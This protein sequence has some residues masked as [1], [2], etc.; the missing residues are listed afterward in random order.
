MKK[1]YVLIALIIAIALLGSAMI[2]RMTE[3]DKLKFA[4][5]RETQEQEGRIEAFTACING[6]DKIHQSRIAELAKLARDNKDYKASFPENYRWDLLEPGVE[7]KEFE[8]EYTNIVR[9]MLDIQG[10]DFEG[11]ITALAQARN[12]GIKICQDLYPIY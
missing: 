6:G 7:Y 4:E 3:L 11:Q 10:W 9:P 5:D 12:E 8:A 2:Y 1:T